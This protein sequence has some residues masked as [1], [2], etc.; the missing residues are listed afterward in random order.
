M[1]SLI[2]LPPGEMELTIESE[3]YLELAKDDL[4][5]YE[6]KAAKA[7]NNLGWEWA[8]YCCYW[9][10]GALQN[11]EKA[12]QFYKKAAEKG[13]GNGQYMV[14]VIYGYDLTPPDYQKAARWFRK[15]AV[16]GHSDAQLKL[17][18]YYHH[19]RGVKQNYIKAFKLFEQAA[20]QGHATAMHNIGDAYENGY[21]V[22]KDEKQAFEWY[23]KSAGLNDKWGMFA[24]GRLLYDG[25]GTEQN[26]EEGR[27]WIGKAAKA[28]LQ[29]AIDWQPR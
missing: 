6:Y 23:M 5:I 8:A 9:G 21:D 20:A 13:S 7:D 4:S 27:R 10:Y 22:K 29:D 11:R 1:D 14:G 26:F 15:A 18:F 2:N 17:G 28:G 16:Q 25:I 19:G 3:A 12:L 24:T